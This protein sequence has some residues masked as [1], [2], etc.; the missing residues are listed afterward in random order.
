V[1][2]N[3]DSA[4][5]QDVELGSGVV[6]DCPPNIERRKWISCLRIWTRLH[7]HLHRWCYCSNLYPKDWS[8]CAMLAVVI[9][10]L[11]LVGICTGIGVPIWR[12]IKKAKELENMNV[13]NI[14]WRSSEN[15]SV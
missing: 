7:P 11:V 1:P 13:D 3:I 2:A 9:G 10:I 14:D 12:L 8:R 4:K 15:E 6:L 5:F